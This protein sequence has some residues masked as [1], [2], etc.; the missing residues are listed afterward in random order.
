MF[1]AK[2]IVA[3]LCL[4]FITNPG[5]LIGRF[6]S[7]TSFGGVDYVDFLLVATFIILV[8]GNYSIKR[9]FMNK[10]A[11][12]IFFA[13]LIFSFY[14]VFLWG[15]VVPGYDIKFFI[16]YCLVR[17]RIAIIGFLFVIPAYLFALK[18][19]KTFFNIIVIL[20]LIITS[21]VLVSII[22]KVEIAPINT[23]ERYRHSGIIRYYLDSYGFLNFL[24]P[25][26]I[27]VYLSKIKIQ[28]RILL[29]WG[30]ILAAVNIIITITKGLY[31][32]LIGS[33][34]AAVY[35]T[36]KVYR[37]KI[38]K[39]VWRAL[40]FSVV[41]IVLLNFTF[42]NYSNYAKRAL[43]DIFLL[44]TE[45]E[46]TDGGTSRM[47]QI[48]AFMY[49][50][51]RNPLFGTGLGYEQ[52]ETYEFHVDQFDATDFSFLAHIMQYGFIGIFIYLIYYY[53][54]FKLIRHLLLRLK[55]SE[56]IEIIREYKYEFIFIISSIAFFVGYLAKIHGIFLELT[57]GELRIE[58]SIYTGILL[59]CLER[60][61]LKQNAKILDK[62][63][64]SV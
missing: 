46:M 1:K 40:M 12:K 47:W 21:I 15:L 10:P 39:G 11:K 22:F 64:Q 31:L 6:L 63:Q 26:S 23:L 3:W 19:L 52:L 32:T 38:N 53:R 4:Y 61:R 20:G 45:G 9:F 30:G 41:F 42:P 27:I 8:S 60:I 50:I 34:A 43:A 33:I 56:K 49:E 5:G 24:I 17:E 13:L 29:F 51:K 57:R 7:K 2:Q 44:A 59:A 37:I 36:T 28:N 48:P 35:F 62:G 16:R 14:K 55:F 58:M 54:V 18:D 25:S